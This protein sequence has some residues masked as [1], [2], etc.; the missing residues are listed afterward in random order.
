M[1]GRPSKR[2]VDDCKPVP[3][4]KM[5]PTLEDVVSDYISEHRP[6]VTREM[7]YYAGQPSLEAAI[8]VAGLARLNGKRHAH[9]RRIPAAVLRHATDRLLEAADELQSCQSFDEL[10]H[11]VEAVIRPIEGIGEMAVYDAALRLGAYLRLAPELVYIH[12]GT[13]TGLTKLGLYRGQTAISPAKLPEAFRRLEPR[14]IE[15][16]LCIYKAH[17]RPESPGRPR[18]QTVTPP[19]PAPTPEI[20]GYIPAEGSHSQR[21]KRVTSHRDHFKAS[22]QDTAALAGLVAALADE[23]ENIRWLAS[24]ALSLHG[25]SAVVRELVTFV[26]QTAAPQ[27]RQEALKVLRSIAEDPNVEEEAREMARQILTRWDSDWET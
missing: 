20:T 19:A 12:M 3:I 2:L 9:Q 17:L 14:E 25:S 8:E 1:S 22:P 5:L 18:P 6:R 10:F 4:S 11:L 13:R 16:C 24:S 27:G 26:E 21:L 7:N 23:D 15:D